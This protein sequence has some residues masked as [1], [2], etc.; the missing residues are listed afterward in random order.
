MALK[1][2]ANDTVPDCVLVRGFDF[3]TTEDQLRNHMS[4]VGN[5]VS[6]TITDKGT[7]EVTYGSEDQA[8]A[9]VQ[10]LQASVINGNKR[11]IIVCKKPR[12]MEAA[13]KR[14]NAGGNPFL[15]GA[16]GLG[17]MPGG[18]SCVLV[19]G[20]DFGTTDDQIIGHMS[21]VGSVVNMVWLDGGSAEVTYSSPYEAG[22]AVQQL[23]GTTI[24]GNKRFI[25][26]FPQEPGAR[27]ANLLSA[28]LPANA[29]GSPCV[30][31]RGF[32]F[33]TTELQ[34][35]G[36][37]SR[38]GHI[39][40]ITFR[41]KGSADVTYSSA[42]EASAALQQLQGTT[43]PGNARFIN[44][45][46][47]G[48][49]PRPATPSATPSAPPPPPPSPPPPPPPP[50]PRSSSHPPPSPCPPPF[51]SGGEDGGGGMMMPAGDCCVVVVG[52]NFGTTPDQ[53][54]GHMS[55]VGNVVNIMFRD[56]G[57]A[58]VTYSSPYEAS[59]AVHE[60]QG[61]TIHGNTRFINVLPE[62]KGMGCGKDGFGKD[63]F[64]KDGFGKD[65]FGK[66]GF[67][68]DGFGKDGFGKD[69][70]GKDGFGK[71]GYGMPN[72]F[73]RKGCGKDGCGKDARAMP[74][75][76]TSYRGLKG[77]SCGKGAGKFHY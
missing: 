49:G 20:F 69:G 17:G 56:K 23:Q 53:L 32:D 22:A 31:V 72:P 11:F 9:A 36:H 50:P 43:I 30:L 74:N 64:G 2:D 48:S 46:P 47:A 52:F 39:V 59:A 62:G 42:Q 67:G 77:G 55:S 66:D 37:M 33:G 16:P 71:D 3:G 73:V 58:D 26:V 65:G 61:T 15:P 18:S 28:G 27:P 24:W 25:D 76:F 21:H 60:L 34:L 45:L 29:V 35:H 51:V 54:F 41:D 6:M 4:T 63:G 8:S 14:F 5:I 19:R 10:H 38:L 75:P 57:S 44:V 70:C 40:N 13:A 7:A 12:D 68:K 1:R